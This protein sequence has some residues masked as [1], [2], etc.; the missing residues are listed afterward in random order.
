MVNKKIARF[1]WMLSVVCC[2]LTLPVSS[3]IID[4][5]AN[6]DGI[7]M[8]WINSGVSTQVVY[9]PDTQGINPSANCLEAVTSNGQYDLIYTD[10]AAPVNF[11]EF[12]KY[13]LKI[14]APQSGGSV[15]LKF[16][17]NDLSSWV[18]IEKT[19]LPGQWDDLEF[20]FSGTTATDYTRMVIFFDFL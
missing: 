3:Q 1:C 14:L 20:D 10:F 8:E 17:N 12:P 18:E 19:P 6:W 16:E 9:N 7:N 5:L 2:G 11:D 13:R 4:T 15:L